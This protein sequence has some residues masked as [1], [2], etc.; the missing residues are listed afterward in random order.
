MPFSSENPNKYQD[1]LAHVL[2]LLRFRANVFFHSSYCGEWTFSTAG[3]GRSTFH[4]VAEG[5]YWL[6]MPSLSKSIK[7]QTGDLLV[8]PHDAMHVICDNEVLPDED[9]NQK[10][11]GSEG[12]ATAMICGYFEFDSP[13]ENPIIQVLPEFILVRSQDGDVVDWLGKVIDL[14]RLETEQGVSGFETVID[15]LSEILFIYAVRYYLLTEKPQKGLL[16]ALLD[17][18][19]GDA[20]RA[21]HQNPNNH[22]TVD[23]LA[24]EA[25]MSRATFASLFAEVMAQTPMQYVTH[26]RM[27]MAYA[28]L[29]DSNRSVLDISEMVGYRSE[30][31]FRKAFKKEMGIT[32]GNVRGTTY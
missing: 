29:L 28:E 6:H 12:R 15:K 30:A 5:E 14:M 8:F 17:V 22:W 13:R 7:L 23:H 11:Q 10:Y 32:P 16:G 19:I 3:S 2:R 25:S 24:M 21:F 1:V 18:R 27:Q 26:W 9:F 20:L 31:A 4:V